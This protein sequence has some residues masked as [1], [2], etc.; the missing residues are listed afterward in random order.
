MAYFY[1][2]LC[3]EL[4]KTSDDVEFFI[5]NRKG[6]TVTSSPLTNLSRSAIS[7]EPLLPKAEDEA[8]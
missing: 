8:S 3:N 7:N 4:R 1:E 6:K 5:H 2:K